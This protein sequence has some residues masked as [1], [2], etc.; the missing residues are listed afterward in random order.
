MTFFPVDIESVKEYGIADWLKQFESFPLGYDEFIHLWKAIIT[1]FDKASNTFTD[2]LAIIIKSFSHLSRDLLGYCY[3]SLLSRIASDTGLT[4]IYD[5]DFKYFVNLNGA[6][7]GRVFTWSYS[8]P[9][10]KVRLERNLKTCVK[11]I[12][13]GGASD[14]YTYPTK[15][16]AELLEYAESKN[17]NLKYWYPLPVFLGQKVAKESSEIRAF[18]DFVK[19]ELTAIE[20]QFNFSLPGAVC[21]RLLNEIKEQTEL[22][23]VAY[24]N[25]AHKNRSLKNKPFFIQSL[26]HPLPSIAALSL[27]ENNNEV[28]SSGHGNNRIGLQKIEVGGTP[29]LTISSRYIVPTK[30]SASF[31]LRNLEENL[32]IGK[33][34]IEISIYPYKR[35][36][37]LI[38]R[39][40]EEP[41]VRNGRMMVVEGPMKKIGTRVMA[42]N[43]FFNLHMNMDIASVLKEIDCQSIIKVRPDS[44]ISDIYEEYYSEIEMRK[45]E[46]VVEDVDTLIFPFIASTTFDYSLTMNKKIIIFKHLLKNIL[47]EARSF[48]QQ[49]CWVVSSKFDGKKKVSFDKTQLKEFVMTPFEGVDYS[50]FENVFYE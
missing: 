3:A 23:L 26:G 24:K 15:P 28:I 50:N 22:R 19:R 4:A 33:N 32:F 31:V 41:V 44:K 7:A 47:P 14:A 45:F 29:E 38:H 34:E 39:F 9:A 35:Y 2:D 20:E 21:E 16:N 37:R 48:L 12:L 18:I 13:L 10:F 11:N 36:S 49:R 46:S 30:T 1:L 5:Q 25:I 8:Q 43:W 42:G 17:W 40:K 6:F 27:R